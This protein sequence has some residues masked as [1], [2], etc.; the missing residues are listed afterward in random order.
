MTR[1]DQDAF[2]VRSQLKAAKAQ[3]AGRL[4][5]EISGIDIPQKKGDPKR[6]ERDEFIRADTSREGLAKLKPAFRTDGKGS[7]T[8]GNASGLNDGAAALLLA[9]EGAVKRF[10]LRPRA[11]VIATAVAGVEPRLMGMGPVPASKLAL[12]RA[13]KTMAEGQLYYFFLNESEVSHATP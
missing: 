9:S 7:V 13:G 6:F 12:S 10:K 1:D 5:A 3:G 2:A 8:A 4:T 11:R